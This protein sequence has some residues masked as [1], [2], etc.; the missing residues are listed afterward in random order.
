ML[1]YLDGTVPKPADEKA[2]A[3]WNQNNAKVVTWIRNR[4]VPLPV[5]I[6]LYEGL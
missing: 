2:V 4:S 1:G 3:T 6:T 5:L